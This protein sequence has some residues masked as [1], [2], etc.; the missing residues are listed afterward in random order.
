MGIA[1]ESFRTGIQGAP[2]EVTGATDKR[3]GFLVCSGA[4][5][6]QVRFEL[7]DLKPESGGENNAYLRSQFLV[8][9]RNSLA[10]SNRS[11]KAVDDFLTKAENGDMKVA[12]RRPSRRLC[13]I[14]KICGVLTSLSRET[15]DDFVHRFTIGSDGMGKNPG[16]VLGLDDESEV[17]GLVLFSLGN[18]DSNG[19]S[20]YSFQKLDE[21]EEV[22]CTVD[23]RV[24]AGGRIVGKELK[25]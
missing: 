1:L 19:V 21:D 5:N 16:M 15:T 8:A 25:G 14:D 24:D 13:G 23:V 22:V 2:F 4:D 18:P 6:G 10:A 9:M 12:F 7:E 20:S 17:E 11:G 3:L